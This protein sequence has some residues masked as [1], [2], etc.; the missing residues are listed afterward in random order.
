MGAGHQKDQDL[1]EN[2]ELP[3]SPWAPG[4]EER[5]ELELTHQWG[6]T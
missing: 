4:K 6:M 2:L 5:L 1:I 3:T